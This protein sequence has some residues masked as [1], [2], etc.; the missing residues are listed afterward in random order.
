MELLEDSWSQE[1]E[2]K[3]K[4]LGHVEE[5]GL[6]KYPILSVSISRGLGSRT[7]GADGPE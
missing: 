7:L 2:K 4:S 3:K 5:E 1:E 6:S